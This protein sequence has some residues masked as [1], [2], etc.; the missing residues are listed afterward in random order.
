MSE[1]K[2]FQGV[3]QGDGPNVKEQAEKVA[4]DKA[5]AEQ[6]KA[7][8]PVQAQANG[9]LVGT[10]LDEEWKIA[11]MLVQSRLL[12]TSYDSPQKVMAARQL[13]FELGLKPL[14]GM[15]Q[16]ANIN[17]TPSIF[18]DLPLAIVR[19]SGQL[20]SFREF[21]IDKNGEEI[22]FKNKNLATPVFGSVCV[23]KRKGMAEDTKAFTLDDAKTAGLYPSKNP[24]KPWAK[25]TKRMLQM[26]AR[27][28][29]LKDHF[30]DFLNGMAIAEYDFD[31]LPDHQGPE[32]AKVVVG[33]DLNALF[34][35]ETDLKA[36]QA[37]EVPQP[38]NEAEEAQI[39]NPGLMAAAAEPKSTFP[40]VEA[41][42]IPDKQVEPVPAPVVELAPEPFADTVMTV[43]LHAGLKPSE[44]EMPKLQ[45]YYRKLRAKKV[46]SGL[47][48]EFLDLL[49]QIEAYLL[50]VRP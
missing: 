32:K 9:M 21:F 15:R 39:V 37:P 24:D 47:A 7:N 3:H 6:T 2:R 10:N 20:E 29:A 33:N 30:G 49:G 8:L 18:G 50:E 27:S 22:S 11:N 13:A 12:P 16:I 45:D 1:E 41:D 25:H 48:P 38:A 31:E 19:N 36:P 4:T 43:G 14:T 40:T 42:T 44:V 34:E 46:A 35:D 28:W 5:K 23:V 17:G 26:R